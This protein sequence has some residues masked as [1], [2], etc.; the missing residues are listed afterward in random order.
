MSSTGVV[1]TFVCQRRELRWNLSKR[2][3]WLW[4]YAYRGQSPQGQKSAIPIPSGNTI[5][6]VPDGQL[7]RR[8][9]G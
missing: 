8:L 7:G 5:V 2:A 3:A 9:I 4:N 1:K 6:A